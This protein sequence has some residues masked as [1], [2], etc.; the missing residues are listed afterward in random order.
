MSLRWP[1]SP[2]LIMI[3]T[4]MSPPTIYNTRTSAK[5]KTTKNTG[6][7]NDMTKNNVDKPQFQASPA[8]GCWQDSGVSSCD[9]VNAS[10]SKWRVQLDSQMM[11]CRLCTTDPPAWS[12][13]VSPYLQL[14]EQHIIQQKKFIIWKHPNQVM[15]TLPFI[16][17]E[18]KLNDYV[19]K[20]HVNMTVSIFCIVNG[21]KKENVTCTK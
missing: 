13:S 11:Q 10:R 12:D 6:Q 1:L 8:T 18:S 20:R 17:T 21:N 15:A 3:M 2:R 16:C 4:M 7:L 9:K 5:P 19:W 14:L